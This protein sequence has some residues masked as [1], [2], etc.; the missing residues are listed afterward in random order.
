MKAAKRRIGV[1]PP[2]SARLFFLED[3]DPDHP[4]QD[5]PGQGD[6]HDGSQKQEFA[7][8]L[9]LDATATAD[10]GPGTIGHRIRPGFGIP[11]GTVLRIVAWLAGEGADFHGGG[12]KLGREAARNQRGTSVIRV[13]S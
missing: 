9:P 7:A 8:I 4:H 12:R 13:G 2:L 11:R 10:P 6:Q 5:Y 3:A 1:L